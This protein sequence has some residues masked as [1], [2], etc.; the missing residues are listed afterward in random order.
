MKIRDERFCFAFY[1]ALIVLLA[2]FCVAPTVFA[3]KHSG[4]K[5]GRRIFQ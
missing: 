5:C 1:Y 4:W 3:G 2:A